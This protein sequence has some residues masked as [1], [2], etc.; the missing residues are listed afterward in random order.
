MGA[1][2]YCAGELRHC[3][4]NLWEKYLRVFALGLQSNPAMEAGVKGP[5]AW[6]W[7]KEVNEDIRELWIRRSRVQQT[8]LGAKGLDSFSIVWDMNSSISLRNFGDIIFTF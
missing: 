2:V 5:V 3:H 1:F 7:S 8:A 4:D 6:Y